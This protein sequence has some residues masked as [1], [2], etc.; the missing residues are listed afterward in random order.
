M[1]NTSKSSPTV[2]TAAPTGNILPA[3]EEGSNIVASSSTPFQKA[4]N[5]FVLF[6]VSFFSRFVV[7]EFKLASCIELNYIDLYIEFFNNHDGYNK[8]LTFFECSHYC[9]RGLY[10]QNKIDEVIAESMFNTLEKFT[11]RGFKSNGKRVFLH[12][13]FLA[14]YRCKFFK[15]FNPMFKY[16]LAPEYN[17]NNSEG[18]YTCEDSYSEDGRSLI[19]LKF[20]HDNKVHD[21]IGKILTS[22]DFS[23]YLLSEKPHEVTNEQMIL[24]GRFL[25]SVNSGRI[26]SLI[27][28]YPDYAKMYLRVYAC[29]SED[30]FQHH[31]F[32]RA[33]SNIQRNMTVISFLQKKLGKKSFE[34]YHLI[35]QLVNPKGF[36][37]TKILPLLEQN[38]FDIWYGE[39]VSKKV[40]SKD[41][42][43]LPLE[44]VNKI[45][46]Y[47]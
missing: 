45:I 37:L 12:P 27:K 21:R 19:H 7:D 42:H 44:I 1:F 9:S 22:I 38:V 6:L 17:L 15:L 11:R 30:I 36:A 35:E 23:Q 41:K 3:T 26:F 5:A 4:K 28:P 29:C 31:S 43:V 18:L 16:D 8:K 25:D 24:R 33:I 47:I 10:F 13:D 20:D 32:E 2:V 39:E 40:D 46:S 34:T 14:K